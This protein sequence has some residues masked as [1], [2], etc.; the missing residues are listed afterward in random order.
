MT[1][2]PQDPS[3]VVLGV[4]ADPSHVFGNVKVE[5]FE[6]DIYLFPNMNITI[7]KS[8][9]PENGRRP[10]AMPALIMVN[11]DMATI[12]I[13]FRIIETISVD[14]EVLWHGQ[15]PPER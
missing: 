4:K 3:T 14:T 6:E 15:R 13:P 1:Q 9:L 5:T 11:A 12:T 8:M 2:R 7:L 10:E